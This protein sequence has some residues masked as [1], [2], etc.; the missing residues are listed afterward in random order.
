MGEPEHSWGDYNDHQL[1][2]GRGAREQL[3]DALELTGPGAGRLAVDL[4]CGAGLEALALARAGWRVEGFDLD[5]DAPGRFARHAPPELAAQVR[6]TVAD[7]ATAPPLPACALVHS[8]YA[9]PYV[10]A[11][12]FPQVWARVEEA[13]SPGGWFVGQLFGDRDSFNDGSG[14]EAFL[15][16]AQAR[17]LFSGWTLHRWDEED[18]DGPS[19]T[20]TKHWHVFHVVARR[21]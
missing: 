9:L 11:G 6:I 2:K 21:G 16:A 10:G 17:S 3:L 1:T 5:P 13:L 12:A 19:F 20:G 18:Q 8:S 14:A 15:T 7:L 4:G